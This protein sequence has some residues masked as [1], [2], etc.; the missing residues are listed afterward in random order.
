MKIKKWGYLNTAGYDI[1]PLNYD[2]IENFN[3][4][5]AKANK[6]CQIRYSKPE[7]GKWGFVNRKGIELTPF[8]YDKIEKELN[9]FNFLFDDND[10]KEIV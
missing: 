2:F 7:G 1:V 5:F 6:G 10:S 8:K 4:G 3:M 9:N